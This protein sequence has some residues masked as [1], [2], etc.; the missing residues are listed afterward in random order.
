MIPSMPAGMVAEWWRQA[1][2]DLDTSPMDLF[3][4][5]R[6]LQVLADLDENNIVRGVHQT[7]PELE[8]PGDHPARRM[9][10]R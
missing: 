10:S 4:R 2:P 9:S 7:P 1:R 8:H 6:R 5:L 3:G